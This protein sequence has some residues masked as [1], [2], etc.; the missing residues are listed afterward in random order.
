MTSTAS[1]NN[2]TVRLTPVSDV[3][4]FSTRIPFGKVTAV[5]GRVGKSTCC[6]R[7]ANRAKARGGVLYCMT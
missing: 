2:M 5:Q 3:D 6:C 7:Q 1:G 4:T